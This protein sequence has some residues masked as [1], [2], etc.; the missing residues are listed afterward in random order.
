MLFLEQNP[1]GVEKLELMILENKLLLSTDDV[2]ELTGWSNGHIIRLCRQGILP[3]ISGNPH[4]FMLK[5]L[6]IALEQLQS[7]GIYGKKTRIKRRRSV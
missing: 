3:Y 4:K 5:P 7:G 6:N 2:A 1:D